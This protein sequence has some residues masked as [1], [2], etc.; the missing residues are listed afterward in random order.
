VEKIENLLLI[1]VYYNLQPVSISSRTWLFF[2][3]DTALRVARK[4][5]TFPNICVIVFAHVCKTLPISL[6][7]PFVIRTQPTATR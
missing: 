5:L 1:P 6:L 3:F 4:L 2:D 7:G